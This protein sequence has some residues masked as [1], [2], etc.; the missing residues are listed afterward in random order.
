MISILIEFHRTSRWA[1]FYLGEINPRTLTTFLATWVPGAPSHS[2]LQGDRKLYCIILWWLG[3]M[4]CTTFTGAKNDPAPTRVQ[5]EIYWYIDITINTL[6]NF[7]KIGRMRELM[8]STSHKNIRPLSIKSTKW[9][10]FGVQ[11]LC[12]FPV[13]GPYYQNFNF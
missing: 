12:I 7:L 2:V 10:G 11:N 3:T 9:Q 13:L 1:K 8:G 5:R 6:R 4:I